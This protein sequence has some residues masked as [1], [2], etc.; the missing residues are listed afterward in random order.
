M[1]RCRDLHGGLKNSRPV[2]G[3]DSYLKG[4]RAHSDVPVHFAF[5][6][7]F[8]RSICFLFVL[9]GWENKGALLPGSVKELDGTVG[10]RFGL[11]DYFDRSTR[12]GGLGHRYEFELDA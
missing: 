7:D 3:P 11:S 2:A 9:G 1:L 4:S 5:E 6:L 8:A 10:I 12:S